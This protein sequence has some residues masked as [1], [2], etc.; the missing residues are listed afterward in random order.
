MA[1]VCVWRAVCVPVLC[2]FRNIDELGKKSLIWY[3]GVIGEGGGLPH[4]RTGSG[5]RGGSTLPL[6]RIEI[7]AR[8]GG[9]PRPLPRKMTLPGA[10]TDRNRE[11]QREGVPVPQNPWTGR[12]ERDLLYQAHACT[13]GHI[14]DAGRWARNTILTI[15]DPYDPC[16][17]PSGPRICP[18]LLSVTPSSGSTYRFALTSFPDPVFDV[19]SESGLRF[20]PYSCLDLVRSIENLQL[21]WEREG[22]L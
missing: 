19:E 17:S 20:E 12:T 2:L 3:W 8:E 21:P 13:F 5:P 10:K 6:R 11:G 14:H 1:C 7:G 9:S 4:R 18:L 16:W 15:V 22:Q